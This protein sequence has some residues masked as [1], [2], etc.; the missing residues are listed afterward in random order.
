MARGID[1][2]G[3]STEALRRLGDQ[4]LLA[5][6]AAGD[7]EAL[8]VLYDRHIR[9]VW[10]L[11]LMSCRDQAAAERVVRDTFLDVWRRPYARRSKQLVVRLLAAVRAACGA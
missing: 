8:G 2:G 10:R 11:A 3:A 6:I 9:S 1:E 5:V 7:P 4:D